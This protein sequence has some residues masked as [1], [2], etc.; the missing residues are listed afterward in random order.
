MMTVCEGMIAETA[1]IFNQPPIIEVVEVIKHQPF[2]VGTMIAVGAGCLVIGF[3]IGRIF[4]LKP[5]DVE[6][7]NLIPPHQVVFDTDRGTRKNEPQHNQ[8]VRSKRDL[9]ETETS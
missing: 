5:L 9:N 2:D 1:K 8:V 4:E 3:V 6:E 7:L